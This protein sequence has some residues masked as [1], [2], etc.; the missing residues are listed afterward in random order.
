MK[1]K[2]FLAVLF[3]TVLANAQNLQL[4]APA[5]VNPVR[6]FAPSPNQNI[7]A[8]ISDT[9]HYFYN[10]HFFRN[11]WTGNQSTSPN[12]L[13]YTIPNPYPSPSF[14]ISHCGSIFYNTASVTI[15]GVEGIVIRQSTAPTAS[16]PVKF[17]VC[18]VNSSN[19]PI[20][21]PLDSVVTTISN[22]NSGDW[23]GA[24]FANPVTVTSKFAVLFRIASSSPLDTIRLF[25]NNASA[26]TSTVP[27]NQRYGENM[28]VMRIN[29]NFQL[30]ATAFGGSAPDYE[31]IVAPRVAINYTAGATANSPTLCT[32]SF[33]TFSN[34]TNFQAILDN[35]QFNFN[36]FYSYW[37]PWA[38]S[39]NSLISN[40]QI[41]SIYRWTFTGSSTSTLYAKQGNALFNTSGLQTA[42]LAVYYKPSATTGIYQS[43]VSDATAQI[44]VSSSF[45]P[46]I[47]VSG[48]SVICTGFTT[49]L[50]AS[51]NPTYTWTTPATTSSSIVVSPSV[52]TIY[53]VQGADPSGCIGAKLFTVNV[54]AQPTVAVS[55]PT[56]VCTGL[57]YTLTANGADSYSWTNGSTNTN[58]GLTGG[59]PG[60]ETIGV[61]GTSGN[62][63][64][65]TKTI[66]VLI[67]PLPQVAVTSS[68]TLFCTRTSGG[69]TVALIGSP[70]GGKYSGI[71]VNS[72]GVYNP[73]NAGTTTAI[74][75]YT[76]PI[77]TCINTS[78]VVLKVV[79]CTGLSD[80]TAL[81]ITAF[82]NPTR[83]LITL[84]GLVRGNRIEVHGATG[85]LLAKYL[86]DDNAVTI[87]LTELP[88]GIYLVRVHTNGGINTLKVL[89]AH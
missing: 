76:D 32:N 79:D 70:T 8:S 42:S 50:T 55:G 54:T 85:A 21:P 45:A 9:L 60:T 7:A 44:N 68:G 39:T 27:S 14:T 15:T 53:T 62:C 75:T 22:A 63:P 29:G 33:G 16:V 77:T 28:G 6:N 71:G 69:E 57:S 35:R 20:F 13:F 18:N 25:M 78:S 89:H 84:T 3:F 30:T 67:K 58:L 81:A 10:K 12:L 61:T 11:N 26:A 4:A 47:T 86:A 82:P 72:A 38:T 56:S 41:D 34:T 83:G 2:L 36:K 64:P 88:E 17:Y 51:G 48:N 37:S 19:F 66:S 59:A 1:T 74:Y 46:S 65:S 40:R 73:I 31:F 43:V 52:T 87:N 80:N 5:S 23:I 24:N 49:T